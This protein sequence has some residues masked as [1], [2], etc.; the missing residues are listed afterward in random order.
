[1]YS[2]IPPGTEMARTRARWLLSFAKVWTV[3]GG[4]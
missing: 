1:M 2:S 4:K 3:S